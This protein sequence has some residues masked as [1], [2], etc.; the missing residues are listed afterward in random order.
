MKATCELVLIFSFFALATSAQAE[1]FAIRDG[2]T[3][4]FL[5]DSITAARTYG[6]TI[7][8]YTLLRYPNRKMRFINSG[9]G[10]DTAAGGVKRL[11]RDVFRHHASVLIV[12]YGVNDIGWGVRADAE[13]EKIYLDA[14]DTIIQRCRENKVRLFLCSAA[15]TAE[16]PDQAEKGFLQQMC[17]KGL[18]KAKASGM[19]VIDLQREMRKVQRK[20]L[21]WNKALK[22]GKGKESLHAADG[23]H[24]NELGHLAMAWAILKG[25]G[26]PADVSSASIDAKTSK[27][28][29][30]GCDVTHV[31]TKPESVTFT[32]L[33]DGL[34]LNQGIFFA[35]NYRFVPI[36][37]E[38]NRYM[39]KITGLVEGKY[40]VLAGGRKVGSW[41]DKQLA[42]G[43]NI[44]S[45]TADGWQP[46]GPWNVQ[47]NILREL[48]EARN[49][50]SV[51]MLL[52]KTYQTEAEA[53]APRRQAAEINN[54]LEQ[55][56]REIAKPR[57]YQFEI[58]KAATK[59]SG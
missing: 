28:A 56:Q 20:V 21:A 46:G 26:A 33:D 6:K 8:N 11:D 10:G 48:T 57:P 1:D 17:D 58:R 5:G 13:H 16:D 3:V 14:I 59:K 32:R 51:G 55:L 40:D 43:I 9:W 35:L 34:P 18:A 24:L 47:A 45:A 41:T 50:L 25:L 15:I 44:C 39:L 37:D 12:A 49:Q 19:G 4:V 23:V 29:Q 27:V 22:D 7:E 30:T 52:S 31:D 38:L 2:D 53:A 42:A 36:F 54:R